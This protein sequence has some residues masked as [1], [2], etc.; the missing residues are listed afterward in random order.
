MQ[1]KK[2]KKKRNG[3]GGGESMSECQFCVWVSF[4]HMWN[5]RRRDSSP[6]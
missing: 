5:D 1:Q 3:G 6:E 4:E 2:K